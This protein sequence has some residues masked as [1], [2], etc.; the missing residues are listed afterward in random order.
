M[1]FH[2]LC[3]TMLGLFLASCASGNTVPNPLS[4]DLRTTLQLADVKVT[5]SSAAVSS[6]DKPTLDTMTTRLTSNLKSSLPSSF[7][8]K[9]PVVVD[10]AITR[11][12]VQQ[13][14]LSSTPITT[15]VVSIVDPATNAVL[16]RYN[17]AHEEPVGV[18][19]SAVMGTDAFVAQQLAFSVKGHI[20]SDTIHQDRAVPHVAGGLAG[21]LL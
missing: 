21:Q 3:V 20:D 1:V 2:K 4:R 19:V 14:L 11:F 15:A 10:V 18:A 7:T 9:R 12:E 17:A 13:R 8:G 6:A 5:A 16:A